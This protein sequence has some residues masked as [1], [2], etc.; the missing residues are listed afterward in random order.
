MWLGRGLWLCL[1]SVSWANGTLLSLTLMIVMKRAAVMLI[2][3]RLGSR[4]L[5][6]LSLWWNLLTE[7]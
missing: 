2:V 4:T 1:S 6:L 7:W 3:A 5:V